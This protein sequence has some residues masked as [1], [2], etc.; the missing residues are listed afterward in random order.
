MLTL[1][2][3]RAR[4]VRPASGRR[5]VSEIVHVGESVDAMVRRLQ[6][7]AMEEMRKLR[8]DANELEAEPNAEEQLAMRRV[9]LCRGLT[10]LQRLF[11]FGKLGGLN[12]KDA[13]LAAGYSLSVSENCKSRIWKPNVVDEYARVCR[14]L[15]GGTIAT[16][17]RPARDSENPPSE[18]QIGR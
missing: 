16:A 10:D 8:P 13:A 11:L 4:R 6:R 17:L 5:R 18:A 14:R 15:M 2:A 9:E 3:A 1:T 12:D 7:E